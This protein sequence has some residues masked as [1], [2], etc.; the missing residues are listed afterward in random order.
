MTLQD[1]WHRLRRGDP[2]ERLFADWPPVPAAREIQTGRLGELSAWPQ[3]VRKTEHDRIYNP[4][5]VVGL[6]DTGEAVLQGWLQ[7]IPANAGVD[8]ANLRALLL[9]YAA[10]PELP[11][12]G[13]QAQAFDLLTYSAYIP[14]NNYH[15]A[16]P[17][18]Q[19]ISELFRTPAT[20]EPIWYYFERSVEELRSAASQESGIRLIVAAS[21]AELEIAVLG[22]L[23]HMAAVLGRKQFAN[24]TL[25]LTV[26]S[27]SPTLNDGEIFAVMR[28]IGRLTFGGSW[29]W[30]PP[31]PLGQNQVG[32]VKGAAL[33]AVFLLEATN[34]PGSQLNLKAIPFSEGMGEAIA[35]TIFALVHPSSQR[36]WENLLNSL[37]TTGLARQETRKPHFHSLGIATLYVPV[38]KLK[39]Y[40]A[41]RLAQA[42]LFGEQN[43]PEGLFVQTTGPTRTVSVPGVICRRWLTSKHPFFRWLLELGDGEKFQNLPPIDNEQ[44]YITFFRFALAEGLNDFLND[45]Q[46]TERLKRA[47][48]EISWLDQ[49]LQQVLGELQSISFQRATT[50]NETLQYIATDYLKVVDWLL[51]QLKNWQDVVFTASSMPANQSSLLT[52]S[53]PLTI[54]TDWR[55]A[56]DANDLPN[57]SSSEVVQPFTNIRDFVDHHRQLAETDLAFIARNEIYRPL[58]ADNQTGLSEAEAY[59]KDS[60]RPELGRYGVSESEKHRFERIRERIGWWIELLPGEFPRIFLV[61]MPGHESTRDAEIPKSARFLPSEAAQ[62]VQSLL[63]LARYQVRDIGRPLTGKWMQN[64]LRE[65]LFNAFLS[66]ASRPFLGYDPTTASSLFASAGQS[67][68]YM[69]SANGEI[70]N[71]HVRTAF[72]NTSS[73]AV[74]QIGDGEPT[75]LTA[76]GFR[77]NIPVDSI[78]VVTQAYEQYRHNEDLHIFPQEQVATRYEDMLRRIRRDTYLLPA[79]LTIALVDERLVNLF[80]QAVFYKV[81][82][83]H[84]F[85]ISEHYWALP[86]LHT[87]EPDKD[88]W[89]RMH[90]S[91][92]SSYV[93]Q[94][95]RSLFEAMRWFTAETQLDN[96][97]SLRPDHPLH[98]SGREDYWNR[99][100]AKVQQHS[101]L[102]REGPA[103]F[104]RQYLEE[105]KNQ[106]KNDLL[107]QA[108]LDLLQ[109]ELKRRLIT[110]W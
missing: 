87:D 63:G 96:K 13:V 8:L 70:A 90:D 98:P 9:T 103:E 50:A 18:R 81:I 17:S 48:E 60:I 19:K 72:P 25:L 79:E 29:H 78:N 85:G 23:L 86:S 15:Q 43:T 4:A 101:I 68:R 95:W 34:L 45:N 44:D 75:R 58:T 71:F 7:K 22:D 105:W 53:E 82:E 83:E 107:G 77:L 99:L 64:R 93:G 69:I 14:E 11:V 40:A 55:A 73:S 26:E 30:M 3:S 84:A 109:I 94:E 62:F 35:E 80:C 42:A 20:F 5:I 31:L 54:I 32:V 67:L 65:P 24:I 104:E 47:A 38:D 110:R 106:V 92:M 39:T 37:A 76:V 108:F 41:A 56:L 100:A 88:E 59:Y 36:I 51:E 21:A 28:E 52:D 91:E 57:D 61:C 89:T 102:Y 2:E 66:R 10:K 49:R 12:Q 16:N 1:L 97:F 6:G 46:E 27:P 74:N 33:D